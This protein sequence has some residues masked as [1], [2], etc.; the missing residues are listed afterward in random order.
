MTKTWDVMVI[1]KRGEIFRKAFAHRPDLTLTLNRTT[2]AS[3]ER[4]DCYLLN[5]T[6]G[7][8]LPVTMEQVTF[9]LHLTD[10]GLAYV[11]TDR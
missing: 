2:R 3:S 11:E 1:P 5:M 10:L 6:V 9:R 7:V 8:S 4:A